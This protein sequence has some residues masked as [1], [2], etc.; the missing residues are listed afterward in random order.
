M[1][2]QANN[3]ASTS[4]EATQGLPRFDL[5][6]W[7][8]TAGSA[9][10]RQKMAEALCLACHEVGFFLLTNHGIDSALIDAVFD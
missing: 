1:N 3:S 2:S 10:E 7:R 5:Q 6:Q 4:A 9:A 8:S